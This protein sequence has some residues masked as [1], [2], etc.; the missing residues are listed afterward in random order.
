MVTSK[1]ESYLHVLL[2]S[3][4]GASGP[5]FELGNSLDDSCFVGHVENVCVVCWIFDV[6]K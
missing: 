2:D 6:S 5:L 4:G 1:D 3:N